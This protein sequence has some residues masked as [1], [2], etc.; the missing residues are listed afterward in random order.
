M[1]GRGCWKEERSQGSCSGRN[2]VFL[3]TR[4]SLTVAKTSMHNKIVNV[5]WNFK[6]CGGVVFK[7]FKKNKNSVF[8]WLMDRSYI[9][10]FSEKHLCEKFLPSSCLL[11]NI[12][13]WI[14]FTFGAQRHRVDFCNIERGRGERCFIRAQSVVLSC[15]QTVLIIG[16]VRNNVLSMAWNVSSTASAVLGRK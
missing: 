5:E 14:I 10:I 12:N 13:N 7:I 9:C 16:T 2:P 6:K 15:L 1:G 8:K 3:E 11:W 4:H